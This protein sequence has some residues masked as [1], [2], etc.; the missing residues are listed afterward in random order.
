[1]FLCWK[2]VKDHKRPNENFIELRTIAPAKVYEVEIVTPSGGPVGVSRVTAV[3][4]SDG[5]FT[6]DGDE[7]CN[8]GGTQRETF[9]RGDKKNLDITLTISGSGSLWTMMMIP[10]CNYIA[11]VKINNPGSGWEVGDI[12]E[13]EIKDEKYKVTV[14][15]IET[16]FTAQGVPVT[17]SQTPSNG[18]VVEASTDSCRP[19]C[20]IQKKVSRL[21]L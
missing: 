9:Q 16:V 15:E 13:F 8:L 4:V 19:Y 3:E 17:P 12:V 18:S 10:V 14:T 21:V 6:T 5:K 11:E 2:A 1:M 20:R 7:G